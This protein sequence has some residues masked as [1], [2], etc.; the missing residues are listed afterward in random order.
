M[1]KLSL[2]NK[3]KYIKKTMATEISQKSCQALF[4]L[5]CMVI[6]LNNFKILSSLLHGYHI[7]QLQNIAIPPWLSHLTI[8]KFFQ[9]FN[10]EF[11]RIGT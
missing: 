1:K 5:S 4:P 11:F 10:M 2:Q 3:D 9:P 7:P 6:E 8:S